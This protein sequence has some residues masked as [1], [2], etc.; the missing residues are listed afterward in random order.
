MFFFQLKKEKKA[1][2]RAA[3]PVDSGD[4]SQVKRGRGRPKGSG[5]KAGGGSAGTATKSKVRSLIDQIM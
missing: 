2:K 3:A 5:K 4:G 1:E